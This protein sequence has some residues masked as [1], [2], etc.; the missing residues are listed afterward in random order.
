M[1]K[2]KYLFDNRD[3]VFML[4]ENWKYDKEKISLLNEF[5]ISANAVYP[6][7][8]DGKIS[9]LR[10]APV[11]EKSEK[12]LLAEL[13]FI[14]YLLNNSYSAANI[15]KTKDQKRCINV[16]TPW[17]N[18]LAVVFKGVSGKQLEILDYSDT[19]YYGFGK[20]LGH[21]HKLSKNYKP[22]NSIRNNWEER[23]D[24]TKNILI[25]YSAIRSSIDEV[26]IL[27]KFF[28]K[29]EMN[30]DN[31]GLI[32]YDFELDNIFY[33]GETKE[34][35]IIDFDDCVYHWF[36]MDIEQSLDS[37]KNEIPLKY[38][39]KAEQIFLSGYRTEM[40]LS[41]DMLKILPIFRRYANLY[42]Y[43]RCLRSI[44]ESWNN[45][46]EW[47]KTLRNHLQRSIMEHQKDFGKNIEL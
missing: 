9:F 7:R 32:H 27:L 46:P 4:L 26:D 23:L 25:E 29:I 41:E 20:S 1:L 34:F 33:N 31:Y 3:L 6:F 28:K 10:F 40:S 45:E 24:W 22:N 38:H 12:D 44:D 13:D 15:V 36:A 14:E 16:A 17:G 42:S 19:L 18:Y 35:N 5:R 43:A 11:E 8:T 37:I 39:E 2:L 47:M 21:L 30:N